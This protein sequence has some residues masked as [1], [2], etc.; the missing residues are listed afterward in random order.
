MFKPDYI[1]T[2]ELYK[3]YNINKEKVLKRSIGANNIVQ[4]YEDNN[5]NKIAIRVTKAPI[6]YIDKDNKLRIN[7]N[8]IMNLED[9]IQ[10]KN[11]WNTAS[12]KGISPKVIYQG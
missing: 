2:D 1:T 7:P 12:I 6:F 3:K 9:L 8:E 4:F 5:N 10:T 11:N